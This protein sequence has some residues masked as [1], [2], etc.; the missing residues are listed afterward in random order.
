VDG[1]AA[2]STVDTSPWIYGTSAEKAGTSVL[3][4]IGGQ[5][6]TATVLTGG[7]WGVSATTLPAG[8][9]QL[10]AEITDAAQNRGTATQLLTIGTG[11]GTGGS[12]GGGQGDNPGSGPGAGPGSGPE[13]TANYQPDGAI[14]LP[15]AT[16]VGVGVFD[17]AQRV[18][19]VLRGK[20][21]VATYEVAVTNRGWSTD[22]IDILG[23]SGSRK[24]KVTY[25]VGGHDVTK[26]VVSGAYRTEALDSDASVTLFIKIT[27]TRASHAGDRRTLELQLSSAHKEAKSDTVS[28]A[29]RVKG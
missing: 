14:R 2:R 29:V 25:S 19:K 23:T 18:T 8:D 13:P 26:E 10:V 11:G 15:K 27:R 1:G 21:R 20:H 12:T 24:F 6:L 5:T 17:G 22:A 4:R 3:V 7:T 28:A 9:H 16:W